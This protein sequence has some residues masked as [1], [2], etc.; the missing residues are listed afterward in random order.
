MSGR[1]RWLVYDWRLAVR[2]VRLIGGDV[3]VDQ[4]SAQ[5]SWWSAIAAAAG[6]FVGCTAEALTR[7]PPF[8]HD[9]LRQPL[10]YSGFVLLLVGTLMIL[11]L[12]SRQPPRLEKRSFVVAVIKSG[13]IVGTSGIV[14]M[15]FGW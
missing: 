2:F 14:A 5:L 4:R 10:A 15:R 3:N 11:G 1:A 6:L 7:L 13:A 9:L 8:I 12:L